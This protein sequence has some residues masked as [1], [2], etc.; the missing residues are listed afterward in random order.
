[1]KNLSTMYY[2]TA[3]FPIPPYPASLNLLK[4]RFVSL[5][6]A[7]AVLHEEAADADED[8]EPSGIPSCTDLSSIP[9]SYGTLRPLLSRG[10]FR[11]NN[12]LKNS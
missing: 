2:G 3:R 4:I 11:L 5:L 6:A 10:S 1:M 8:G 7:I 12:L 9:F